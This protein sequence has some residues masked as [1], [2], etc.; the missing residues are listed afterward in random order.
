MGRSEVPS[1]GI[2]YARG[3]IEE[4]TFGLKDAVIVVTQPGWMALG[5]VS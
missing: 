1:I 5:F 2:C 4:R 3:Y